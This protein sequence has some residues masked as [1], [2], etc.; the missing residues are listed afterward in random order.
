M[1]DWI[2]YSDNYWKT[3]GSLCQYYKDIP[4]VN[5]NGNTVDFNKAN[6]TDLFNFKEKI[7]GKTENDGTKD[8]E[9][10]VPLKYLSNCW[11]TL[12]ILLINCEFNLDLNRSANY[13]T[14]SFNVA[15]EGLKFSKT[16]TKFYV[17]VVTLS[18]QDNTKLLRPLKYGFKRKINWNEYQSKPESLRQNQ[19]LNWSKF[20][21]SKWTFCF[22]IRRWCTKNKQKKVFS[23]KR[24]NKNKN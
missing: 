24:R 12:E 11:S 1:Y 21:R 9:V 3:S 10:M 8:V 20:S 16:N 22:I 14:V 13:V 7:K 18:T 4:D 15:N 2:E 19:H 17:L 5:N 6:V 23:T